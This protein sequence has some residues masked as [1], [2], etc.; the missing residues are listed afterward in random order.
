M[1][2]EISFRDAIDRMLTGE[3]GITITY[4]TPIEKM[5]FEDLLNLE[6]AGARCL[7]ED[8]ELERAPIGDEGI[9]LC[10][11]PITIES[12][13]EDPTDR[14]FSR[15]PVMEPDAGKKGDREIDG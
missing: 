7:A 12:T 1:L 13:E 5:T 10:Q 8:K 6:N 15:Q 4:P 3:K 9:V 11:P 14:S 2:K